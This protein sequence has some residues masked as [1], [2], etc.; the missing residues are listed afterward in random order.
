MHYINKLQNVITSRVSGRGHRIGAVCVSVCVSVCESI[1]KK[2]TLGQKDCTI[3]ET[4]E[5]RE[6][7]GVFIKYNL[8]APESQ[9]M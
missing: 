4:R 9:I 8:T 1:T 7:S 6:R 2:G 5:V 3:W